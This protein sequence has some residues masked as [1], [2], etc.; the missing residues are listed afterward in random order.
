ML[1]KV[2]VKNGFITNV[3]GKVVEPT[4]NIDVRTWNIK[5]E[6]NIIRCKTFSGAVGDR[7]RVTKF[8]LKDSTI[9]LINKIN[10]AYCYQRMSL[11]E[12]FLINNHINVVKCMEKEGLDITDEKFR[13]LE[14]NCFVRYDKRIFI[15][16]SNAWVIV[17]EMDNDFATLWIPKES[18]F[19]RFFRDPEFLK[20]IE[21][22]MHLISWNNWNIPEE[23]RITSDDR[24]NKGLYRSKIDKSFVIGFYQ[25]H[26]GLLSDSFEYAVFNGI[27]DKYW[28]W[29]YKLSQNEDI[30]IS[31]VE[32]FHKNKI[33]GVHLQKIYNIDSRYWEPIELK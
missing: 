18:D 28:D 17:G 1:L 20:V 14:D 3:N 2:D 21:N 30:N 26:A 23:F 16:P 32:D 7:H 6:G 33:I 4:K 22:E 8:E 15:S 12:H 27:C 9:Y 13:Q 19:K 11:I 25:G 31:K 29:K 5:I 24:S 10:T